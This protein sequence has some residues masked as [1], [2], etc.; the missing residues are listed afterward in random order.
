MS[1]INNH[2]ILGNVGN[3]ETRYTADGKAIVNMSMAV[4]EKWKDKNTGQMNEKTEWLRVTVFGKPAEII[5]QYVDKGDKLYVQGKV[6]T[7][8]WQDSTG[9]DK[10]TTETI[11]DGFN[12]KFELLGGNKSQPNQQQTQQPASQTTQQE[13]EASIPF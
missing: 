4:S 6:V 5:S 10:Y 3:I 1:G 9:Q 11:V 13:Y 2:A 8:K 7:R 12:G